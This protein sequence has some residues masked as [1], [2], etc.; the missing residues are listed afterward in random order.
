MWQNPLDF[1]VYSVDD[2]S[3]HLPVVLLRIVFGYTSAPGVVCK[4]INLLFSDHPTRLNYAVPSADGK[5][6][7]VSEADGG[8]FGIS[9]AKSQ[10]IDL[11]NTVQESISSFDFKLSAIQCEGWKPGVVCTSESLFVC[12]RDVSAFNGPLKCYSLK[13]MRF[14][15]EVDLLKFLYRRDVHPVIRGQFWWNLESIVAN[16]RFVY[17]LMTHIINDKYRIAVLSHG[18]DVITTW[19][20]ELGAH[21]SSFIHSSNDRVYIVEYH[22]D[23]HVYTQDG[24]RIHS[25]RNLSDSFAHEGYHIV[26]ITSYLNN[27][28]LLCRSYSKK[29]S[30]SV[31]DADGKFRHCHPILSETTHSGQEISISFEHC[32]TS[33]WI[34]DTDKRNPQICFFCC[35][36]NVTP[37][38]TTTID[39]T[40]CCRNHAV[41]FVEM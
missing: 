19:S 3:A 23:L 17:L 1:N 18:G 31:C 9:I 27:V 35:T 33:M 16:Q 10:K 24:K 34:D 37:A 38:Q 20:V 15:K 8:I 41:A 4:I 14:C 39:K 5:S 11:S 40:Q 7:F 22:R 29:L 6:L 32:Y 21:S 2:V 26:G 36:S 25:H 28:Y 13:R 12:T 30:L